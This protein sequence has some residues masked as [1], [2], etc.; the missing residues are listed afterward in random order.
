LAA[1]ATQLVEAV[2]GELD[3]GVATIATAVV[4]GELVADIGVL[5]TAGELASPEAP[6]FDKEPEDPE[7]ALLDAGI[8]WLAPEPEPG[9]APEDP[10]LVP[11]PEPEPAEPD[12]GPEAAP[13][14]GIVK[15]IVETGMTAVDV[16]L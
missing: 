1:T 13:A 7:P 5:D 3:E 16:L 14:L 10:A 9:P 15:T 8:E 6:A 2:L 11:A 4:F 12:P